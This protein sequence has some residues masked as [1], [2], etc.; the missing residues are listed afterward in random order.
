MKMTNI[1]RTVSKKK[2]PAICKDQEKLKRTE[3]KRKKKEEFCILETFCK[4]WEV[5]LYRNLP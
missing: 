3:K 1:Q 5:F 2:T 4:E